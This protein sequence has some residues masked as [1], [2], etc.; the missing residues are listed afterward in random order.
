MNQSQW[1][2]VHCRLNLSKRMPFYPVFNVFSATNIKF[3]VFQ[4]V[5]NVDSV[6]HVLGEWSA[7]YF[8]KIYPSLAH[9]AVF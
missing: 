2:T 4:A 9:P 1:T 3:L 6:K 8:S 5:K 7:I